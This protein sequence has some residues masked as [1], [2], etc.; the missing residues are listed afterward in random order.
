MHCVFLVNV[1]A[2]TVA[3]SGSNYI[4]NK[5]KVKGKLSLVQYTDF[6]NA[7]FINLHPPPPKKKKKKIIRLQD[8][9]VGGI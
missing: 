1:I 9:G 4:E 6:G 3:A 7:L 5:Q 2:Y 8:L